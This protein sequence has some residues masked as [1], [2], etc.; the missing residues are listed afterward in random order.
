MYE[1]NTNEMRLSPFS[2][3]SQ[4]ILPCS[5]D[6]LVDYIFRLHEHYGETVDASTL[7]ICWTHGVV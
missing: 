3:Y 5:E 2:R 1:A 6:E 4:D 7:W